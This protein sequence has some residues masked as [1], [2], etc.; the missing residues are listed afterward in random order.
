[1]M[2]KCAL[3]KP[4]FA[5]GEV[6]DITYTRGASL[7]NRIKVNTVYIRE[8]DNQWQYHAMLESTGEVTDM[9][10][11]FI[12]ERKS[13]KTANVYNNSDVIKRYA[14]GWRFCGNRVRKSKA[15]ADAEEMRKYAGISE[16]MIW[17]ALDPIGNLRCGEYGVWIKY[18]HTIDDGG[19]CYDNNDGGIKI[20]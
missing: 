3:S 7:P 19:A 8:Q 14:Q 1:M 17:P 12:C 11:S 10:E 2:N 5:P 13:K 16:I 15:I 4:K 6:I 20:K 9:T 18:Y